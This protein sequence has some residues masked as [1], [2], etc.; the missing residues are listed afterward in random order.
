MQTSQRKI[1]AP[2]GS[3]GKPANYHWTQLV[4][5]YGRELTD[6]RAN[7]AKLEEHPAFTTPVVEAQIKPLPKAAIKLLTKDAE[8]YEVKAGAKVFTDR[9][10]TIQSVAPE[11]V[12]QTGIRF[13]YDVTAGGKYEPIAFETKETVQ[14]LVGYFRSN[15]KQYLQ[16][17]TLE[18]D[19]LAAEHGG[20]ETLIENAATIPSLPAVDVHAMKYDA[21]RHSLDVRGSGAFVVLGVVPQSATIT[22]R[23]AN[24]K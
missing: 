6:F 21:G 13:S 3:G 2:G 11:L 20:G 10:M 9:P 19:A 16:V 12:G 18:T 23:D 22:P 17:P 5:R 1:P 24:A 14:I 4:D 7:V 15:E 8:T